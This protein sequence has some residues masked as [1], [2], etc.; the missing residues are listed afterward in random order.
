METYDQQWQKLRRLRKLCVLYTLLGMAT[1]WAS[2]ELIPNRAAAT[3]IVVLV[4]VV[5]WFPQ[6]ALYSFRCP[7]CGGVF[8]GPH[9]DSFFAHRCRN[10]GLKV[11]CE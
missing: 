8:E 9:L 11:Y 4:I 6:A 1:C 7:K 5:G 10:C 2:I 3:L